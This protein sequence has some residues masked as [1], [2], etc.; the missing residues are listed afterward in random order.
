MNKKKLLAV[1]YFVIVGIVI[2]SSDSLGSMVTDLSYVKCGST[3]GIPRPL[4][5]MTTIAYTL[6][7]VGVPII[8]VASGVLTMVKAIASKDVEEIAKSKNK[9]I[10]KILSAAIVLLITSITRFVIYRITNNDSDAETAKSCLRCF[11]FYNEENCLYSDTGNGVRRGFY[12]T[13][14]DSLPVNDTASNRSNYAST[15]SNSNVPGTVDY[16]GDD[17]TVMVIRK[18]LYAVETGGQVY[19]QA[20]YDDFTGSYTNTAN[21]HAITI[22]A[23]GWYGPE[24]KRLLQLIRTEAPSTFSQLDTAGIASDLD[25][26]DWSSYSIA[27]GSAKANAIVAIISSEDG[28]KLQDKLMDT[29]VKEMMVEAQNHGVT[30]KKAMVMFIEIRHCAGLGG[31][32]RIMKHA[33]TPYTVDSIYNAV[34]QRYPEDANYNAPINGEMFKSR[35]DKCRE[36]ANAHLS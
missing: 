34:T 17:E 23:G 5:Q 1:I 6:I 11:L 32:E 16:T 12:T 13:E 7:M 19:G 9:L 4:P 3:T 27:K 14:P 25:A 20:G 28:K 36:F 30:D 35:H 31:A 10:K 21:E 8:L 22:G 33:S 24:A 15:H 26:S 2:F 29:Q 18:I